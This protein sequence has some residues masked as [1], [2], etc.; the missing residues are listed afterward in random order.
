M[1]TNQPLSLFIS[2]K[3]T[4]LK[5]ERQGIQAA[6]KQYNMYGWL[7]ESDAGARP[8]PIRSTYLDEVEACDIYIG[9][10]WL[11]YGKYTVEEFDH[12]RRLGKP[13]LVYEKNIDVAQRD[14]DLLRFLGLLQD[15]ENR[16]GLTIAWFKTPEELAIQVQRDVLHLL[17]THFR[18]NR[19][20]PKALGQLDR[21]TF[22]RIVSL[23]RPYMTE[24]KRSAIIN[25]AFF[26]SPLLHQISLSGDANTFTIQ[27]VSHLANYGEIEHGLPAICALLLELRQGVGYDVS[28]EIDEVLTELGCPQD[29]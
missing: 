6:L 16:E 5:N 21:H 29:R 17:I 19:T 3:M 18:S 8:E 23:A 27:L 24:D 1:T 22:Q 28:G 15:V 13:C 26:S 12:A 20:Q 4:E 9:V 25:A 14:P 11:G 10:F 7:W 2:S